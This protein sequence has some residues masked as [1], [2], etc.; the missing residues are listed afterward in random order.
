MKCATIEEIEAE[1]SS[2]EKDVVS[3]V[4]FV[5]IIKSYVN[6]LF[7]DL[8]FYFRKKGWKRQLKLLGQISTP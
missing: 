2:I 7:T 5:F 4:I 3:V 6:S 1:K 8:L